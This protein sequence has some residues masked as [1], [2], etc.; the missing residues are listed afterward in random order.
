M[1][2]IFH[3]KEKRH[4]GLVVVHKKYFRLWH[5]WIGVGVTWLDC[6]QGFKCPYACRSQ[7]VYQIDIWYFTA[8]FYDL[9]KQRQMKPQA[10]K[11][12]T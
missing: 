10:A 2:P 8:S 6:R 3:P 4:S 9:R 1:K 7:G 5:W 12:G 11:A